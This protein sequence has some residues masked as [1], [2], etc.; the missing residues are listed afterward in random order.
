MRK[1]AVKLT[2]S[3]ETLCSLEDLRSTFGAGSFICTHAPYNC[4]L[5]TCRFGC[6][7]DSCME[8]CAS[9]VGCSGGC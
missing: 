2:L 1:K 9:C 4:S 8:T 6:G 3:R 7:T 5:E